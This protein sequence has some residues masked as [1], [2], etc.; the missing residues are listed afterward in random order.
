MPYTFGAATGDD[1]SVPIVSA[2]VGASVSG[3]LMAWV[4]PTTLTAGRAISGFGNNLSR[5]QVSATAGELEL[6]LAA[7]TTD[8]LWT[9]SGL[10]MATGSWYFVAIAWT[11]IAGPTMDAKLW[12]G[13]DVTPPSAVSITQTTAPVGAF[14]SSSTWTVGNGSGAATIAW[15][16]DIGAVDLVTTNIAAGAT[17]PF[18]QSAYG[19]FSAESEAMILARYVLPVWLGSSPLL[20]KGAPVNNT[21][22]MQ[23]VSCDFSLLAQ[24]YRH[25]QTTSANESVAAPTYSGVTFSERG[26]PRARFGAAIASNGARIAG[27]R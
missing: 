22:N 2:A 25:I 14:T 15:Q 18:V 21:T 20:A 10:G 16:G 24:A 9:S 1:V 13:T 17:H 11:A 23:H 27:R 4:Y 26:Q 8:G 3:L 6:N 5:I 7:A 19:A 12:L